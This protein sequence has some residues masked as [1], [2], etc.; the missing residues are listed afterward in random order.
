MSACRNSGPSTFAA[1][2]ASDSG[3]T[4]MQVNRASGLLATS[5][6]VCAPTPHPA[7]STRLPG[8]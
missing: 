5:V 1:A 3:D 6:T 2:A 8:G 7:S 4:S